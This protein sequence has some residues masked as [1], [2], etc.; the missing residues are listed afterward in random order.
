MRYKIKHFLDILSAYSDKLT[1]RVLLIPALAGIVSVYAAFYHPEFLW[2]ALTLIPVILWS[3]FCIRRKKETRKI[4]FIALMSAVLIL[5][6]GVTVCSRLGDKRHDRYLSGETVRICE[7]RRSLDGS[8]DLTAETEDGIYIKLLP[9]SVPEDI[10]AGDLYLVSGRLSE[11]LPAG[12]PGEFDYRNYL[13]S[14]GILY[15]LRP[16]G[17]SGKAE[18]GMSSYSLNELFYRIRKSLTDSVG[19]RDS[20][21]RSYTAAV[22]LGDS[23]L[24]PQD[25]K[26]SFRNAG[27]SHLLAVSGMH[28][29]SFLMIPLFI[30]RALGCRKRTARLVLSLSAL[31]TA[32][33]TGFKASVTRAF[34]MYTCSVWERDGINACAACAAAVIL[35]DPFIVL[36]SGFK[37]SFAVCLSIVL[38]AGR[39]GEKLEKKLGKTVSDILAVLLAARLG[40]LPF[41]SEAT[42]RISPGNLLF[43]PVSSF[44]CGCACVFFVFAAV[45]CPLF[46]SAFSFPLKLVFDALVFVA[47]TASDSGYSALNPDLMPKAALYSALLLPLSLLLPGSVIRKLIFKTA[48][49]ITALAAGSVFFSLLFPPEAVV[50]FIDVGQGDCALIES[51]GRYLMIDGGVKEEGRDTLIPLLYYYGIEHIDAAVMSHWDSDHAAG[52]FVLKE[53]GII[54]RIYTPDTSLNEKVLSFLE[55]NCNVGP[56]GAEEYMERN[57]IKMKA[58]DK[59]SLGKVKISCIAPEVLGEDTNE[60]SLVLLAEAG[61]SR[62]LFTG[63]IDQE[64]EMKLASEGLLSDIDLLKVAHHGSKYSS[65]EGFLS[66]T[67][68]EAAVISVGRYNRYGHPSARVIDALKDAGASVYKTSTGGMITVT[69]ERQGYYI[70]EFTDG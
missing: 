22:C 47:E 46:G 53:E 34:F 14:R 39:I 5:R 23:S 18:R 27:M 45:L 65:C 40:M 13:R 21:L 31:L 64:V 49:L 61:S 55:S 37:M 2:P 17:F 38:F 26:D 59:L 58:G 29:T 62:I 9:A 30:C 4:L 10:R 44:L 54:D 70:R 36:S 15:T 16:D 3:L 6:G 8:F 1:E 67:K 41:V 42:V 19:G 43:L 20:K 50:R 48:S 60:N 52:L 66:L 11:P 7:A 12:N 28:F 56:D 57:M 32:L 24:L 63:D 35:A 33:I 25:S 51:D 68:P 69:I